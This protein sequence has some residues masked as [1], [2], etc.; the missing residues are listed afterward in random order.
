MRAMR[1]LTTLS[2]GILLCATLSAI[3]ASAADA[4]A[5]GS[6]TSAAFCGP[7]DDASTSAGSASFT[8]RDG[9][10]REPDLLQTHRDM[11][12]SAKGKAGAAF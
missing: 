10:V 9:K 8:G 11:P 5:V 7:L 4:S 6:R 12:K 3:P 1:R 2:L